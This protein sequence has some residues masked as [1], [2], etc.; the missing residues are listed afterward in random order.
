[1]ANT[2]I[3]LGGYGLFLLP[4]WL[5]PIWFVA[6]MV[7]ADMVCGRYGTDPHK[8]VAVCYK[9]GSVIWLS[10]PSYYSFEELCLTADENLFFSV[11]YNSSHILHQL[12]PPPSVFCDGTRRYGVPA[13]FMLKIY[14]FFV[15]IAR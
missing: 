15:F 12:F 7:V 5:W 2:V 3:P 13:P 14:I 9:E 1:M 10:P 11:R 8:Q 6:D 4:M